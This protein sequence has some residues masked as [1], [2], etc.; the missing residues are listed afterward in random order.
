MQLSEASILLVDDEPLLL[1]LMREWLQQITAVVF[2]ASDG[3][4]AL[5]V[6]DAQRIDLIIT[7]IRMPVMDGITLLRKVKT[8]AR[9]TPSLI[10]ITGF[11]DIQVRDA[12]DLGAEALVE[13]PIDYDRLV[14][15]MRRSVLE[16]PDRWE[17][18]LDYSGF[19]F[20]SRRFES[21]SS[22]LQQQQIAFGCGGFCISNTDSLESGAQINIELEFMADGYALIGQG[23][24]QWLAAEEDRMGVELNYVAK[25][26]RSRTVQLMEAA[27]SF[28]PRT[29]QGVIS[30]L[31]SKSAS[32]QAGGLP[33]SAGGI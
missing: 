22:A 4:Q 1:A 18:R 29:T 14:E 33:Q 27:T 24:I 16:P 21:V 30:P 9:C 12:Y 7:D 15:I 10:F 25:E 26:S 11:A 23:I 19:S 6:M 17:R 32:D 8:Q 20:L 28:I 2:C 31:R 3:V 5:Q 13:K